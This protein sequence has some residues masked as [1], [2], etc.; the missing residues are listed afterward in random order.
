MITG[1][2]TTTTT[3]ER[4]S[5]LLHHSFPLPDSLPT[6]SSSSSS[7]GGA[8]G[9]GG[10]TTATT[11]TAVLK[12]GPWT[13]S[14]DA[15]LV[16]YVKKHGEG[17]WNAV[18]KNSGL[19]RCGKSCRLRW[20]NHLRPN[21]K[22]GA[23]SPEEERLIL[24]LHAKLGNKWARMAAQLP[25]RTDNEI[26]NY[27]NTRIKRRLRAGLPLYPPDIQRH[28]S[29]QP[30]LTSPS[31]ANNATVTAFPPM[32]STLNCLK[33]QPSLTIFD[34][35]RLPLSGGLH[36]VPSA[37]ISASRFK[38]FQ[39]EGL[40]L[41][42]PFSGKCLQPLSMAMPTPEA[43]QFRNVRGED[44][45]RL[46]TVLRGV[47]YDPDP[48]AGK[49]PFTFDVKMELPSSQLPETAGQT[50]PQFFFDGG[51]IESSMKPGP[52][53]VSS[54]EA[55]DRTNSGLLDAMLQEVQVLNR[56]DIHKTPE[57]GAGK[58]CDWSDGK[59]VA[60]SGADGRWD[61]SSSVGDVKIKKEAGTDECLPMDDEFSSLLDFMPSST[62]ASL[63]DW[64]SRS[65]EEARGVPSEQSGL[66]AS[67]EAAL[68][69]GLGIDTQQ[70]PSSRPA[71]DQLWGLS[72]CPWNNM[73]GI[74]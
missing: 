11:A 67:P 63:P 47:P 3:T 72:S 56:N 21:L 16:A 1:T 19:S 33:P 73:P 31:A 69:D 35:Q 48:I 60:D 52:A 58:L 74:C 39:S 13:S 14:E 12:K 24:E 20:A 34:N 22:K 64:Y 43:Q 70:L 40:E 46:D 50:C 71:S 53:P 30:S 28:L 5:P 2:R 37:L 61:A 41:G 9:N 57:F 15:I 68:A 25:G 65:S 6:D 55:L 59:V 8:A 4:T 49:L 26:K 51:G 7:G 66:T 10:L 45:L 27:W 54:P 32:A 29:T 62:A 18:Q 23:F 38:S 36:H 17:N 42:L 44:V